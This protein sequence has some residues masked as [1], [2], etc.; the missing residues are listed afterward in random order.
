M[1]IK[2]LG[3][4]PAI[5]VGVDGKVRSHVKDSDFD[6]PDEVG[7]GLLLDKKNNF[8]AAAKNSSPLTVDSSPKQKKRKTDNG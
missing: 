7:K 5:N 1:K 6:Y 4:S 8:E 2:Y 3:P